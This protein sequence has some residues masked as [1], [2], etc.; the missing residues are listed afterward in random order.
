LSAGFFASPKADP[1]KASFSGDSRDAALQKFLQHL[2]K[3]KKIWAGNGVLRFSRCQPIYFFM[4][5]S[6]RLIPLQSPT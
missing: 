1:K 2:D 3:H 6:L 5:F 4:T